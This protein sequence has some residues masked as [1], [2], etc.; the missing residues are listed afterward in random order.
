MSHYCKAAST[1]MRAASEMQAVDSVCTGAGPVF[2]AVSTDDRPA[3]GSIEAPHQAGGL[4]RSWSRGG[5]LSTLSTLPTLPK[6]NILPPENVHRHAVGKA[7]R[8]MLNGLRQT[9]Q[10]P[11]TEAKARQINTPKFHPLSPNFVPRT[12]FGPSSGKLPL[13]LTS[14][15]ISINVF[16]PI[17]KYYAPALLL[18]HR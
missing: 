17:Q 18:P 16:P 15:D 2:E 10:A 14:K 12:T 3:H 6:V 5:L 11:L 4:V 7:K 1:D 13:K 9:R 8:E